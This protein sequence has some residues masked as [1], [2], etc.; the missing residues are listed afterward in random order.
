MM[1]QLVLVSLS[2]PV[3]ADYALL[4]TGTKG[5]SPSAD[6]RLSLAQYLTNPVAMNLAQ[7]KSEKISMDGM[8]KHQLFVQG[9]TTPLS[10][11]FIYTFNPLQDKTISAQIAKSGSWE[12][13]MN[14]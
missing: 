3:A 7:M 2:L 14:L 4:Q 9:I 5:S 8:D 6:Q 13:A 1:C 10:N 12:A 11:L